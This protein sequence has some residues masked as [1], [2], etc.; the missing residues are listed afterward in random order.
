MITDE[1]FVRNAVASIY[2]QNATRTKS[3]AA[4][5]RKF[6]PKTLSLHTKP[7]ENHV[8]LFHRWKTTRPD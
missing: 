8:V 1:Q 4:G 6:Q 3:A 2:R 7:P 5:G